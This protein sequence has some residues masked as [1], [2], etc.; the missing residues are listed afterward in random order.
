ML[1]IKLEEPTP[2]LENKEEERMVGGIQPPVE[3]IVTMYEFGE[4]DLVV[5]EPPKFKIASS[6]FEQS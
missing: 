1:G 4:E 2:E 5:K 3:E 6:H